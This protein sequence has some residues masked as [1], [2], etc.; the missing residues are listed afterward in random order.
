MKIKTILIGALIF[1]FFTSCSSIWYY[2]V[3]KVAP[4]EDTKLKD[5]LLVYEDQN[6]KVSYN[7]WDDGGNIGFA[8]FNKTDK[9]IFVNMEECFFVLN[10]FAHNY[11]QNRTYTKSTSIGT[12]AVNSVSASKSVTGLNYYDLIQTNRIAAS[13]SVG[14]L[15]SSGFA[16]SYNEEKIVCIPSNTSKIISEFWINK[17]VFRDCDL[18]KYPSKKQVRT[19]SFTKASSPFAFSN[20]IAYRVGDSESLIRFENDFYVTEIS[21]Y[22]EEEITDSRPEEYCGQKSVEKATYFKSVSPDKFYI[23]YTK[24]QDIWIH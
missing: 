18:Y 8:I 3:Y 6:I 16:V 21:N 13:K 5:N 4:N 7:L 1:L 14:S 9:S 20:R 19:K 24:G 22:P 11:Y 15:T 17:S 12:T 2:Q 23:K 10:G